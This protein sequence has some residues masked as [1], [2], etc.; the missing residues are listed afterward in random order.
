MEDDGETFMVYTWNAIAGFFPKRTWPPLQSMDSR[1]EKWLLREK[2]VKIIFCCRSCLMSFANLL[3]IF[4]GCIS[5]AI[6]VL[7]V[8]ITSPGNKVWSYQWGSFGSRP[9]PVTL[10]L[11]PVVVNKHPPSSVSYLLASGLCHP[12]ILSSPWSSESPVLWQHLLASTLT[13]RG[14]LPMSPSLLHYDTVSALLNTVSTSL[15][16]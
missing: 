5:K 14:Q 10:A 12:Q 8:H 11:Q 7:A 6:P 3:L 9:L 1:S 2:Q 13:S 15:L 4:F 16:L